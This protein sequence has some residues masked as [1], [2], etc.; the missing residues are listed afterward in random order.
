VALKLYMDVHIPAA[1]TAGL[2]RHNIDVLTSQDDGTREVEDTVLLQRATDLGRLLFSQDQ[3]FLRIASQWQS[4][5]RFFSGLV[6]AD[7]QGA[8]IGQCIEDIELLAL[9][10]TEAE[11]ANQVISFDSPGPDSDANVLT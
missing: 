9:C 8:S 11:V 7:Q 2:V 5:G 10:C 3:D 6:F 1:I 4:D